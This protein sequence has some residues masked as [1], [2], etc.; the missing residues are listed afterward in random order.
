M[1]WL[2][3]KTYNWALKVN[4]EEMNR[5]ILS[6]RGMD[7]HDISMLMAS[8]LTIR[9]DVRRSGEKFDDALDL[10]SGMS[11]IDRDANL[12]QM[13]R[14]IKAFQKEGQPESAA[15]VMVWLFSLRSIV[16]PEIRI[17]GREMWGQ[18]SRGFDDVVGCFFTINYFKARKY[19]ESEVIY[20]LM[21]AIPP[22][23]EPSGG[24]RKT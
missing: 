12:I 24:S 5:F 20:E 11:P 22:G 4:T 7:D 14:Y 18:L 9:I 8:A 23:L 13:N 1:S 2:K 10:G 21:H 3:R 16:Y 15:G 17:L 6:L 19:T